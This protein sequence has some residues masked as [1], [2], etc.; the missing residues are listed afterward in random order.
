MCLEKVYVFICVFWEPGAL[1][2]TQ[3]EAFSL[4]PDASAT[5]NIPKMEGIGLTEPVEIPNFFWSMVENPNE[6]PKA[7]HPAHT[8][9]PSEGKLLQAKLLFPISSDLGVSSKFIVLIKD[10]TS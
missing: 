7:K 9:N 6:A 1:F 10:M 3:A 8:D 2:R 4:A 5:L